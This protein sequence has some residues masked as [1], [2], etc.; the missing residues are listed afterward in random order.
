MGHLAANAETSGNCRHSRGDCGAY[1]SPG[2]VL[3]T[4]DS[5]G[6]GMDRTSPAT[7]QAAVDR[8]R[9]HRRSTVV[10]RRLVSTRRKGR[11]IFYCVN[12]TPV[13]GLLEDFFGDAGNVDRQIQLGGFSLAFKSG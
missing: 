4:A 5:A 12:S 13:R 9:C 1:P 10:A 11:H 7:S 6:I 8:C 2:H 3:D